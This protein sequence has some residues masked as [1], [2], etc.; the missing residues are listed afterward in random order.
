MLHTILKIESHIQDDVKKLT[1]AGSDS[2]SHD[3]FGIS[4]PW[5]P[6]DGSVQFR[7]VVLQFAYKFTPVALMELPLW[8]CGPG[9]PTVPFVPGGPGGPITPDGPLVPFSPWS[10]LGPWGPGG[11]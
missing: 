6:K 2:V 7:D 1:G 11:P 10:P 9:G 8:P 3:R 5:F 4:D